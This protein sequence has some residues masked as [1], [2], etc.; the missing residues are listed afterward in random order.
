[1]R[2]SKPSLCLW[3]IWPENGRRFANRTAVFRVVYAPTRN[4]GEKGRYKVEES[5]ETKR[6]GLVSCDLV[7]GWLRFWPE[8]VCL[9]IDCQNGR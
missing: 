9:D 7:A 5:E 4:F 3:P 2:P 1:M 8:K 6:I